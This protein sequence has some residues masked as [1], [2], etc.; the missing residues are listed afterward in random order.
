MHTRAW[1][2]ETGAKCIKFSVFSYM[3]FLSLTIFYSRIDIHWPP[4][5]HVEDNI[6]EKASYPYFEEREVKFIDFMDFLC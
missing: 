3:V 4:I 6:S 2:I 1:Y 5:K